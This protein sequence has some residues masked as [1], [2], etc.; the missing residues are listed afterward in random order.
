MP[1]LLSKGIHNISNSVMCDYPPNGQWTKCVPDAFNPCPHSHVRR[2]DVESWI[3]PKW[4]C[5][6]E[7]QVECAMQNKRIDGVTTNHSHA[8]LLEQEQ[9]RALDVEEME[10]FSKVDLRD[11]SWWTSIKNAYRPW[12]L[13]TARLSKERCI[14][15]TTR[16]RPSRAACKYDWNKWGIPQLDKHIPPKWVCW[17]YKT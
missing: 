13:I 16:G 4:K 11:V 2:L 10:S 7:I 8:P 6:V 14:S 5:N 12:A 17:K 9:M 15:F 3:K 1:T